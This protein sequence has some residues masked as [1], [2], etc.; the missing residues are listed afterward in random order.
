ML[1]KISIIIPIYN[2]EPYIEECLQSVMRQTYRGMIECILVDDC[3]TDKSIEIAKRIIAE[4]EG[5]I[6][7][8]VLHH[9]QNRGLSAARNTGIENASGDYVYF[10]DSD[11]WISDDCIEK[12]TYP[13]SFE[14]YDF[15]V[16]D[17]VREGVDSLV[18]CSEGE[19]HENGLKPVGYSGKG[20]KFNG[21]K[22]I[23]VSAC[24]KLFK[25]SFL[26]DNQLL[27]EV[28]RVYEDSIF[29]FDL[30]CVERKYYV[31]KSYTYYYRK[32]DDSITTSGSQSVKILN[33]VSLFQSLRDRVRQDKCKNI[34]GIYDYYLFWV[35]RVFLWISNV[36]MDEKMLD[37]VQKETKG[38]LEVIPNIRYLSSKHDRLIYLFC[39]KDQTY[40]RF[41]YVRQQ[42]ADKYA[43]RLSGR[44][45]RN[46]LSLIPT[47]KIKSE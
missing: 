12:L 21:R 31:V 16:G 7:F 4:Y 26:F 13:L 15:V 6:E 9:E 40:L 44:I 38:F 23:P 32:R 17:Y 46:L 43:N 36:E 37:Y 18:L 3:G 14:Q 28:G 5:P 8:R 11:D 29:Y 45:M 25:K 47:K 20:L 35:K 27:F 2:V 33:Y 34:D 41:Q 22:G 19:Y 24:N 39:R 1:P 30:V 42:Y 10:L